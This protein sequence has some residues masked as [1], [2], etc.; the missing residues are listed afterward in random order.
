MLRV[1]RILSVLFTGLLTIFLIFVGYQTSLW[2][3][4]F[5]LLTGAASFFLTVIFTRAFCET[6]LVVSRIAD[7]KTDREAADREKPRVQEKAE[8]REGIQWNV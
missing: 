1:F 5:A 7:R 4:I 8:P 2:L 6:I 3:G